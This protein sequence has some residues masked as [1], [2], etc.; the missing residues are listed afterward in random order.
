MGIALGELD[1][2][3]TRKLTETEEIRFLIGD[4]R[5]L[6]KSDLDMSLYK[7]SRCFIHKFKR[8]GDGI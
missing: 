3:Q 1:G 6:T 4:Q 5:N 7:G 2:N 8:F